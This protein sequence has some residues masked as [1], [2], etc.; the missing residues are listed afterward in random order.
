MH[1]TFIILLNMIYWMLISLGDWVEEHN[2]HDGTLLLVFF[3]VS[4]LTVSGIYIL[5]DLG[6][7]KGCAATWREMLIFAIQW[8]GIGSLFGIGVNILVITNHWIVY[9]AQGGWENFLNGIE[10]AVCFL[11]F[12]AA[13]CAAILLYNYGRWMYYCL[14]NRV[15]KTTLCYLE[16][17]E[18]YLMLHRIKKE[19]DINRDKWIGVGGHFEPGETAKECLLREVREETGLT[20]TKY[21]LRG[22]VTFIC[23]RWET[24]Q[25]YLYTAKG[26]TGEMITCSEGELEWIDKEAVCD[27]PIWQGDKIFF[28]LLAEEAP[29]FSLILH[30]RGDTLVR[31][32]LNG[33]EKKLNRK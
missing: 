4:L 27:L 20:L 22:I 33:R 15:R 25:M 1:Y 10:Y 8:V 11:G 16:K 29:F 32:I 5:R 9:Q 26:F 12:A 28:G 7:R 3:A 13:P 30:Y 21:R 14:R 18:K 23:D 2:K 19:K 6:R 24:E 17:D 31:C